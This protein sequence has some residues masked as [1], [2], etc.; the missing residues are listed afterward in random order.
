MIFKTKNVCASQISFDVKDNKVF[1]IVFYGGCPGNLK[2]IS[3]LC[4]G[5]NIDD[6][7]EKLENTQCRG[8]TSCPDQL[9]KALKEYK[10]KQTQLNFKSEVSNGI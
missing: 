3:K 2:G 6:I 1:N 4:D 9:A 8:G 5:Q 7:I 10:E